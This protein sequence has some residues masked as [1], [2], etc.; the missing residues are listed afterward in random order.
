[1]L[2]YSIEKHTISNKKIYIPFKEHYFMQAYLL[3]MAALGITRMII[4]HKQ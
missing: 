2:A 1:M 4:I 3:F